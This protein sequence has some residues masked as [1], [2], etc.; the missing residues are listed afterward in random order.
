MPLTE[1]LAEANQI[2]VF[3]HRSDS[4]RDV[5][6]VELYTHAGPGLYI[7]SEVLNV[8]L[9]FSDGLLNFNYLSKIGNQKF[10]NWFV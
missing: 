1:A 6:V 4:D 9:P 8:E 7:A 2:K 3:V 10:R 5:S